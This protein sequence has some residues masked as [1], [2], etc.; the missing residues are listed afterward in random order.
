MKMIRSFRVA[1]L[2]KEKK[3]FFVLD[4]LSIARVDVQYVIVIMGFSFIFEIY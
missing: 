2:W 3:E 1:N 4:I